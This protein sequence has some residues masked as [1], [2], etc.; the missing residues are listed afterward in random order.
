MLLLETWCRS[1]CGGNSDTA[2]VLCC[3]AIFTCNFVFH[4][5]MLPSFRIG[6]CC[7]AQVPLNITQW[8]SILYSNN[9]Y[10]NTIT[11]LLNWFL[12]LLVGLLVCE[13]L[14]TLAGVGTTFAWMG[15]TL[16]WMDVTLLNFIMIFK[17]VHVMSNIV[18]TI[19]VSFG[20]VWVDEIFLDDG[21]FCFVVFTI[22]HYAL[23]ITQQ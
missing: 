23:C 21:M 5:Q 2:P 7:F 16:A 1:T 14:E 12:Q 20:L 10:F 13:G 9:L 4:S 17:A 15:A 8:S 3:K 11:F 22:I 6:T 18:S 19:V